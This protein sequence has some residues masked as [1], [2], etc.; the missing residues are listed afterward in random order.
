MVRI[1]IAGG[2]FLLGV[3]LLLLMAVREGGIPTVPVSH[4]T[5][6]EY[7]GEVVFLDVVVQEIQELEKP[8]RFLVLNK[9]G[10][11]TPLQVETRETLSDTFA[12]GSDLRVKGTYEPESKTFTATWVDTKCPSRYEGT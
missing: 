2:T 11:A 1:A 10:G 6:G 12:Q 5:S 4:V 7:T 3:A 9:E 8:A